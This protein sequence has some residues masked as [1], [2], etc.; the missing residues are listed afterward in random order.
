MSPPKPGI[1]SYRLGRRSARKVADAASKDLPK[2]GRAVA[3]GA[4]MKADGGSHVVELANVDGRY[5][6]RCATLSSKFWPHDMFPKGV[7][8]RPC[9]WHGNE[10]SSG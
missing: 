10:I 4:V 3:V 7:R 5:V 8:L 6:L 9:D 1:Y 2:R